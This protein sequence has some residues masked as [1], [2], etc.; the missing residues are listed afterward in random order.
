METPQTPPDIKELSE[1]VRLLG[2]AIEAE[3]RAIADLKAPFEPAG[4]WV[5]SDGATW[6]F[7]P[8]NRSSEL[9]PAS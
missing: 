9:R 3:Q 5:T 1:R 7:R 6:R 4:F 8:R 2:E